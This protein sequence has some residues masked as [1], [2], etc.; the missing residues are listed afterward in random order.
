MLERQRAPV[1]ELEE[2]V[3]F[4]LGSIA[5]RAQAVFGLLVRSLVGLVLG[6]RDG[7]RRLTRGRAQDLVRVQ[8]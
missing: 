6:A 2:W 7:K 8:R 1:D 3:G 4:E 5:M